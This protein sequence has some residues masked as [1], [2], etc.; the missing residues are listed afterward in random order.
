MSTDSQVSKWSV[1][2]NLLFLGRNIE[3]LRLCVK[4]E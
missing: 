3:K 1:D 2:K 4:D